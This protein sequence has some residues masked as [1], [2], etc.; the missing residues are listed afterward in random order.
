[1]T[2]PTAA[3]TLNAVHDAADPFIT[4]FMCVAH[5]SACAAKRRLSECRTDV[6][7]GS[8]GYHCAGCS[9]LLASICEPARATTL[10]GDVGHQMGDWRFVNLADIFIRG[11][12]LYFPAQSLAAS[13]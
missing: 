9:A 6:S 11:L 2:P 13:R 3:A 5:C 8:R 12:D 4:D 10:F 1:M 7:A